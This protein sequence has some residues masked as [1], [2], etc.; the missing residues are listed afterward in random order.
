MLALDPHPREAA[1]GLTNIYM[2]SGRLGEAEPLLRRL[3]AERPDDAGIHL[4]LG[5]VLAAQGKK[6][7][8]IT[9]IQTALK[10]APDDSAAQHDLADLSS[11]PKKTAGCR[12]VYR[13]LV[14]GAPQ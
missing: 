11:T 5:R 9:E 7:D 6:D 3:A 2:K 12:T 14:T 10:L 4:Q 8:A 13:A 1:I